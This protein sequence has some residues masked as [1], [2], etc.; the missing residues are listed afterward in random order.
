MSLWKDLT[1][2]P[3]CKGGRPAHETVPQEMH[4]QD[5]DKGLQSRPDRD[6]HR[7]IP[8]RAG[9]EAL[10]SLT[11]PAAVWRAAPWEHANQGPVD[12]RR[13][14]EGCRAAEPRPLIDAPSAGAQTPSDQ[15]TPGFH[16]QAAKAL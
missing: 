10:T 8:R 1:G 7:G 13:P 12:D 15:S 4:A 5:A 2:G 16:R 3:V 6:A 11:C 14:C 9:G